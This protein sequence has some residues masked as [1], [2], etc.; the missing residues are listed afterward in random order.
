MTTTYSAR[1]TPL[2]SKHALKSLL[3]RVGIAS[4]LPAK[5]TNARDLISTDDINDGARRI[6]SHFDYFCVPLLRANLCDVLSV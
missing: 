4:P 6:R 5:R 1:E 3:A 2:T